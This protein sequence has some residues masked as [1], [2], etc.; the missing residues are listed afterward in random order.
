MSRLGWLTADG[1]PL[2]T[3]ALGY[4]LAYDEVTCVIPGIRTHQQLESSLEAVG[5]P[6]TAAER[7]RL[8]S[9]WDDFTRGG[10]DL[11]PW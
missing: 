5:R 10:K 6:V 2:A 11:L 9:F 7:A 1:T 4:L 3:R 8:E